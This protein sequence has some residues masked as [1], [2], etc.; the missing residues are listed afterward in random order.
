M[1]LLAAVAVAALSLVDVTPYNLGYGGVM[2]GATR[3]A[4]ER[5]LGRRLPPTTAEYVEV[6]G[7]YDSIT[8][9]AGRRVVIQWS[10]RTPRGTV[11]SIVVA[12]DGHRHGSMPGLVR[13][14]E[15]FYPSKN[16]DVVLFFSGE[17]EP[18]MLYIS[19]VEC[20]D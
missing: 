17:N 19:S 3:A 10:D 14:G 8:F 5:K 7:E 2:I 13:D 12:L 1:S 15:S 20:T 16:R 11:E 4:V 18:P 9:M 6:C